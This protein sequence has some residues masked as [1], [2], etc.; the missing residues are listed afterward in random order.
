MAAPA[1]RRVRLHAGRGE[2]RREVR[3]SRT[4]RSTGQHELRLPRRPAA[5][6]PRHVHPARQRAPTAVASRDCTAASGQ[7]RLVPEALPY[8]SNDPGETTWLLTP[9]AQTSGLM[10]PS[11]VGPGE[12]KLAISPESC[13]ARRFSRGRAGS[14]RCRAWSRRPRSRPTWCCRGR[15][16]S[17][18]RAP[19][20]RRTAACA[21]CGRAARE[22]R[23]PG[24]GRGGGPG[25]GS[26]VKTIIDNGFAQ[27]SI[28]RADR[29]TAPILS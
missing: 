10:R 17:T 7:E 2:R 21:S 14:S 16:R 3:G 13:T 5:A 19:S 22:R 12:L 15:T 25:A 24:G 8:W 6:E 29:L 11:A 23:R 1:P 4:A 26:K 20:S 27:G 18:T 9:R 28:R